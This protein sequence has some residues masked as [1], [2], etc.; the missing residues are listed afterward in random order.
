[1]NLQEL[2]EKWMMTDRDSTPLWRLP[3]NEIEYEESDDPSDGVE[4]AALAENIRQCGLIH[5][6]LV[7]KQRKHKK[8][9]LISG[10]RRLEATK[11]L[12]RTHICAIVIKSDDL[13][14]LKISL[15]ENIMRKR[16]DYLELAADFQ[17]LLKVI[18]KEEAARLFSMKADALE[19]ILSLNILSPYEKRLIRLV[20]LGEG[21]AL[22]LCKIENATLRK[23]ILEKILES[24]ASCDRVALIRQAVQSPDFRLTQSEK[25]FVRDIRVFL[26]TVERAAEMMRSA[27]FST[28]IERID[29]ENSYEFAIRV[30]KNQY[31]PLESE[32]S[33]YITT[34][35]ANVPRET[36][37]NRSQTAKGMDI[38][39]PRETSEKTLLPIDET[40]KA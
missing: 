6:I 17:S 25:I 18:P 36:S 20:K 16:P 8:Y 38:N 1:M 7:I 10:Q 28:Q 30:A 35:K 3:V 15:S 31:I 24:G 5:P 12:G 29:L 39:V 13:T 34:P 22:E 11:L 4:I 32:V 37:V 27:G 26:N 40:V 2:L 23:L 9:Q 14:P 19:S 21:E 33:A